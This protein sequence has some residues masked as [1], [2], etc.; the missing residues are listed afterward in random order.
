MNVDDPSLKV[1]TFQIMSPLETV[2]NNFRVQRCFVEEQ[3]KFSNSFS[4]YI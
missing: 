2:I 4:I 3:V 1:T